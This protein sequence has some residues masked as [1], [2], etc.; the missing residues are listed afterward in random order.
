[1]PPLWNVSLSPQPCSQ[2]LFLTLSLLTEGLAPCPTPVLGGW[3]SVPA[4]PPL[5]AV[6]YN[7]LSVFFNFVRVGFNLFTS[8]AEL[9][10][11]SCGW[12]SHVVCDIHLLGL[13]IYASSFES[14]QQAEM[15]GS[16]SHCRCYWDWVQPGKA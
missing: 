13:Q 15:A 1:M 7:S 6:D 12:G 8:Y 14:G 16:F 10:S 4:S 5:S 3:F 2:T 11:L 9:C